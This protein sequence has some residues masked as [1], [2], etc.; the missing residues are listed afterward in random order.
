MPQ[1][2]LTAFIISLF[3]TPLAR[4]L[5]LAFGVIDQPAPRKI[6]RLPLPLLGGISILIA[7]LGACFFVSITG[8]D[9]ALA[10][11]PPGLLSWPLVLG[12]LWIFAL[13]VVDDARTVRPRTKLF[14]QFLAA[15][16]V[17][18][19]GS[20][21][22]ESITFPGG[23][24]ELGVFALPAA[25]LWIVALVNA[26]NLLDGMDGL[27]SG[28]ALIAASI[29][30][31]RQASEGDLGTAMLFFSIA[32]AC[33]S[34]LLFNFHPAKIFLGDCGSLLLGYLFAVGTLL[35]E[36]QLGGG[37]SLPVE[38]PLLVFAVPVL[39]TA[40]AVL[41]RSRLYLDMRRL[42]SSPPWEAFRVLARADQRHLH[43]GLL[44]RGLG[45]RQAALA[46]YLCA[47][48][49]GALTYMLPRMSG[50]VAWLV[51]GAAVLGGWRLARALG[52]TEYQHTGGEPHSAGAPDAEP[53][54]VGLEGPVPEV[55]SRAS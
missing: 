43:H 42:W 33:A 4:R 7:V 11:P 55:V 26:W 8:R 50:V 24:V 36:P 41:R 22:I 31:F 21:R 51:L 15:L 39:D 29:L 18:L 2:F 40:A 28:L 17:V 48:G 32:G 34:F 23:S 35:G 54:R 1:A 9:A 30:G 16:A 37:R 47:A 44:R 19:L 52:C 14:H 45:Q 13:G 27:A 5:A 10:R 38:I 46:L 53:G 6:H 49:F 3:C 20:L 25:I 12:A